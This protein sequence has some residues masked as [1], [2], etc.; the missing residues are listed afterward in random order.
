MHQTRSNELLSRALEVIPGGVNSPVRAFSAVG[1]NPLFMERG[2]G[3]HMFDVDG[4]RFLDCIGS[5][6]PLIFGHAHPRIREALIKQLE[7]GSTFGAPTEREVE[8]AERLVQ[9]VPS[10]EKVRLVSSGTEATMSAIR[11]A[12]G[13]TGRDK[14]LKFEG[15]YHGHGDS[16]LAKAG[17]GI[18]TLGLP[19]SA[20]VPE[21]L[22][23]DTLTVPYNDLNAVEDL[24]KANQDTIACII[25]EPVVGNSG[26]IE[27]AE[28]FL[29]GLRSLTADR[30]I[31]LIFD[32]VMTGFRLALGGAQ[33]RY[34]ITPDM[35]TMGKIIGGGLP[36]AAYGG[37][38]EIMNCVAPIGPVYQAG[39]LSGNALAVTAGIETLKMISEDP[40]LY[41][42]LDSN[43]IEVAEGLRVAAKEA[44]I[45]ATVN[46]VGS[47]LTLFFTGLPVTDYISA[48]R[49]DTELFAQFF[50]GMLD[51]GVYFPPSQFESAFLSDAMTEADVFYLITAANETLK[52][53]AQ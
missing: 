20:G 43:G 37:R 3:A 27:P 48:K 46:Q 10:C 2:V 16:L 39:T 12:R 25:L 49:S 28:G 21:N 36:L 18:A 44:G 30:G 42:R 8:M 22:T 7:F 13:F 4:N 50:R 33:E 23:R 15:N 14:I 45:T 24:L 38:K 6:G 26:C 47:M 40:E 35:T 17:S 5:W 34:G 9:A 29:E 19:D 51:R 32:E 53:I 52:C 1:G 11:V 41:V 31:V